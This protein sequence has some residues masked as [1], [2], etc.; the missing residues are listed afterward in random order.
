[1]LVA[2][3]L[4]SILEHFMLPSADKFYGDFLISFPSRTEHL[5]TVSKAAARCNQLE[6]SPDM[7]PKETF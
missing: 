6:N 1:M 2:D 5:S 7:K 4:K 3:A